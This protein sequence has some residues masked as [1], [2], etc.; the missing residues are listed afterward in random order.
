MPFKEIY[1]ERNN[2]DIVDTIYRYILTNFFITLLLISVLVLIPDCSS[3]AEIAYV[4]CL[5]DMYTCRFILITA[6][7]GVFLFTAF[8]VDYANMD[9][10]VDLTDSKEPKS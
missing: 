8:Q 6:I 10:L 2:K 3:Y 7:T 4:I 5:C 9:Y 1:K